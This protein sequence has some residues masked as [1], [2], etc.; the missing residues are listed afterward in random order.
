M[1]FAYDPGV[2][3]GGQPKLLRDALDEVLGAIKKDMVG[4]RVAGVYGMSLGSF[5]AWEVAALPGIMRGMFNTGGA[6]T[7]KAVWT[8]PRLRK[9]RDAFIANGF[10]QAQVNKVWAPQSIDYDAKRLKGKKLFVMDSTVDK[11]IPIANVRY[12]IKEYQ[13]HGMDIELL[14]MGL[15]N[16]GYTIIRNLF[17]LKR[18]IK[19]FSQQ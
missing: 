16:H 18:T 9:E 17:R 7:A 19:F 2:L 15:T 4:R 1:A 5:F 14:E 6:N 10:T 13:K 11:L 8:S 3:S 12:Y